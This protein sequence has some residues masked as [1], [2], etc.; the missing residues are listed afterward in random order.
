MGKT[1]RLSIIVCVA[2]ATA[3]SV[4]A[5]SSGNGF[6]PDTEGDV[7]APDTPVDQDA[8]GEGDPQIDDAQP[9]GEGTCEPGW[10]LCGDK[11]VD[12]QTDPEHC[13]GCDLPCT[14]PEHAGPICLGGECDWNCEAGWV[15]ADGGEANGCE[16]Q[17][18]GTNE[19]ICDDGADDDCDGTVDCADADCEGAACGEDGLVCVSGS[20]ACSLG[21]GPEAACGDGVD[22][23][24]DGLVDCADTTCANQSCGNI[25]DTCC[26]TACVDTLSDFYN[27]GVCG[28]DCDAGQV[29]NSGVC[30]IDCSGG[31]TDCGGSCVD[32]D[33]S[34]D[35]CGDC[36]VP[37]PARV[38]ATRT[39]TG[40]TCGFT[41]ADTFFDVD[42]D[43]LNGCECHRTLAAE[44]SCG[45]G[46]DNDCDGDLDC[47]DAD[48]DGRACSATG[49]VCTGG[50]CVCPGGE[51]NEATCSD[52]SDNDCDGMADCADPDCNG[53]ACGP[54]GRMCSG[55]VCA[56]PG[57]ETAELTCGDGLDNDCDGAADCA[58]TDCAN[59]ACGTD[60]MLCCALTCVDT[61]TNAAHCGGCGAGCGATQACVDGA[62]VNTC[63]NDCDTG[64]RRCDPSGLNGYQLC[65]NFDMDPC[66]EW[67]ST[68]N[69]TTGT[70]CY[71]GQCIPS[72][73]SG[74]VILNE[75]LYD[76]DSTDEDDVF[77]EL[78]GDPGL[79]LG[80]YNLVGVNG[81]DGAIYATI[82]LFG[83][84]M[85]ADG[86]FV[87][88]HPSASAALLAQADMQNAAV[89]LQNGPDGVQLRWGSATVVDALGYGDAGAYF[90][91]EGAY[92][93]D[94]SAG[95]SLSRNRAHWDTDDN[96]TDFHSD[97]TPT[98]GRNEDP[99][100]TVSSITPAFVDIA[101]TGTDTGLVG[102]DNHVTLPIGFDF[103]F[104]GAVYTDVLVHA[105]GFVSFDLTGGLWYTNQQLPDAWAPNGVVACFWDDLAIDE[106][107]LPREDYVYTQAFTSAPD[108]YFVVQYQ[109]LEFFSSTRN[110]A[111]LTFEIILYM[112]GKIECQYATMT[113]VPDPAWA[114]GASAT[115]GIENI[116]ASDYLL[117]SY[118][119]PAGVLSPGGLLFT[120]I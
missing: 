9:E 41:C 33:T 29:C 61:D 95:R 57:G 25:T 71:A 81:N 37:C 118:N 15:D 90:A 10:E 98:P 105:N 7:E 120:P 31:L 21:E 59:R 6:I 24:C 27:C 85:P 14:A 109:S 34:V 77:I 49:R 106:L 111:T 32:T 3:A 50:N 84:T 5:C 100:Y 116:D 99:S 38:N 54:Y 4:L 89:D 55:R 76:G 48:C 107:A 36:F 46:A 47:D 30:A 26:G 110:P 43:P 1:S 60:G 65:G 51:V 102:D 78:W 16:C 11:C 91:G 119:D 58:D 113:S 74:Y 83:R 68:T 94:V 56:C 115:V 35:H 42:L 72:A 8:E 93:P 23:D 103:P 75:V 40:G 20:C 45:D 66:L 62:C 64:Q 86:Y 112:S 73:P 53:D 101:A 97:D 82:D 17:Q 117:H 87:V 70:V 2:A 69:C 88:V 104:F 63:V 80:G 67:S 52:S 22:N 39:C 92:A 79:D 28:H 108:P 18:Q 13:G 19:S 44:T 96:L 114:T 12:T